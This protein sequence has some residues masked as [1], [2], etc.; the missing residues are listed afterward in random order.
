MICIGLDVH[1]KDTTVAWTDTETGE[2]GEPYAVATG[3]V[4]EHLTALPG[5]KRV[6]MEAGDSSF[7]L[8]GKLRSCRVQVMVS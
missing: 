1:K 2:L 3:Q 6:V 4:S 5:A 7:F 8:A